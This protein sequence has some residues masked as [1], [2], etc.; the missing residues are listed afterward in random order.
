MVSRRLVESPAAFADVSELLDEI[1][2]PVDG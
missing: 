2:E 1:I